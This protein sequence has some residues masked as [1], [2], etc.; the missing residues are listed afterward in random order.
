MSG[1]DRRF[2]VTPRVVF[3]LLVAAFGVALMLDN[4]DLIDAGRLFRYWP[5]ALILVGLLKMLQDASRSGRI[6]GGLLAGLGILFALETLYDVRLEVWRWW[7]LAIVAFGIL[8]AMRAFRP[9]ERPARVQ[10]GI[11][12]GDGRAADSAPA[13]GPA[14]RPGSPEGTS[15][16]AIWSGIERRITSP[17]FARANL[18]AIMGGI[19]FDLR[20]AGTDR[21]QAVIDVFVI[22]GGIEI[23]VPPD[24]AVSN[25]VTAIMG[26]ASDQTT[27][28]QAARH[29]LVVKGVVLM[30]GVD[31]KT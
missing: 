2:V 5:L 12:F 30:G 20:Q 29:R 18:T 7:P 17:S 22:W 24:W 10:A 27:G 11:V 8:I 9:D 16:L 26:G 3:G 1:A 15:E 4:L 14:A 31:I 25:Q 28:T 13:P 21:G 6:A 19:E 23:I